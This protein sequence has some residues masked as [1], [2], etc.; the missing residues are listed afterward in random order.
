MYGDL[1]ELTNT[2]Q[3][4]PLEQ[5][6]INFFRKVAVGEARKSRKFSGIQGTGIYLFLAVA[7][8]L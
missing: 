7:K 1:Q 4:I 5:K 8:S 2:L 6:P 3:M